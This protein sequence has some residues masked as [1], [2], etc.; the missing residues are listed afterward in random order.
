MKKA[1]LILCLLVA[2]PAQAMVPK[3]VSYQGFLTNASGQ[4]MNAT[5]DIAFRLYGAATGG[6]T[7][8]LETHESVVVSNGVFAVVLGSLVP[9]GLPFDQQYYLGVT[10]G[11]DPEMTPRQALTSAPYAFRASQTNAFV[12][13]AVTTGAIQFG[14]ITP[15]KLANS[16][17]VGQILVRSATAWQ[18]GSLP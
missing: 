10:V 7:L 2:A 13:N 6:P 14:T 1:I 9:L 16:C 12:A 4:P 18:C 17:A 8:W 15:D 11:A 3:T 5:V